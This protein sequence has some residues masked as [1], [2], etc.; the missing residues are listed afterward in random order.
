MGI[1]HLFTT[2]LEKQFIFH[3][4]LSHSCQEISHNPDQKKMKVGLG[5]SLTIW[6]GFA[7]LLSFCH[8]VE[9]KLW[10]EVMTTTRMQKITPR[11]RDTLAAA[12]RKASPSRL[13]A[14][15]T[16]IRF[17][18]TARKRAHQSKDGFV[19]P[20]MTCCRLFSF[21]FARILQPPVLGGA[22]QV[23]FQTPGGGPLAITRRDHIQSQAGDFIKF[24][25]P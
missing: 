6:R 10:K 22:S 20:R 17:T 4:L 15:E 25:P 19:G 23:V 21:S 14:E 8:R 2:A 13:D 7:N 18:L 16:R 1:I 11:T 3:C 5:V 9:P 12:I 24:F